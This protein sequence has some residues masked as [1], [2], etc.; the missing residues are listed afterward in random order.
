MKDMKADQRRR[1]LRGAVCIALFAASPIAAY[2][3]QQEDTTALHRAIPKKQ[4]L[5]VKVRG[6]LSGR[7]VDLELSPGEISPVL[8]LP[9]NRKY[10][11]KASI[12]RTDPRFGDIYALVLADA[13]GK[14]LAEMNIAGNTTATFGDHS[15]QIYL[16][17]I[18]QAI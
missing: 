9:D 8:V 18:E 17:P 7:D 12:I 6:D 14:T 3:A 5:E 10:R 15:V 16:L 1:Y 4:I 2:S 11:V 13:K